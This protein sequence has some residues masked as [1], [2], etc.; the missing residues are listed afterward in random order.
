MGSG[1]MIKTFDRARWDRLFGGGDP[2]AEQKIV[3]AMLWENDGYFDDDAANLQPGPNRD[4]VLGSRE[5]QQAQTLARHLARTGFTYE[6][7]GAA[8]Q[9]QLDELG[10][11]LGSPEGLGDELGVQWHSPD[12]FHQ[13]V[14]SELFDRTGNNPS[15]SSRISFFGLMGRQPPRLPVRY[16]PLLLTGRRFGTEAE[17]TK[18]YAAYYVILSPAEVVALK[19][20]AEMARDASIPWRD[21]WGRTTTEEYLLAPLSEVIASGR[22]VLMTLNY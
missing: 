21:K 20:E 6:G 17:P 13:S 11:H 3:D 15:W 19:R 16:L 4:Q 18:S 2:D 8:Q 22:W 1:W 14:A 9:V 10:C 12:F 5:G 7:L